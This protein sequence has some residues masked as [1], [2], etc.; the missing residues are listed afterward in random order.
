MD[1]SKFALPP[2][3]ATSESRLRQRLGRTWHAFFARFPHLR[4]IQKAAIEPILR[5]ES[6]I[7][8]APTAAGKTEA[9]L[10]PV[11][12]RYLDNRTACRGEG[13]QVS[14]TS[15]SPVGGAVVQSQAEQPSATWLDAMSR[16]KSARFYSGRT[17]PEITRARRSQSAMGHTDTG[18]GPAILIVAP[19]KALCNDLYR[20]MATPIQNTGLTVALRTGDNPAFNLEQPP[21]VLVTTPESL[22]SLLARR[23]AAFRYIESIIIDEIHLVCASGRGDQLQCL[24]AR[25]RVLCGRDFQICASSATVPELDRIARDFIGPTGRTLS[26]E[27]GAREIHASMHTIR[28]DPQMAIEDTAR[29]LEQLLG[30][31]PQ[32]KILAFCNSRANVEN[33][34]F[35]LRHHASSPTV[36][37]RVFAHHGSLSKEERLRTE[38]Q[39]LRARNAVCVATSTLE[40]GIDIGDVDRIVLLGPPPDVPS[41][42]Q[43]IGRGCRTRESVTA[44]CLA[45][46]PFSANRFYHLVECARHECLFPD[47][48]AIRP[49]TLVQQ[50]LSICLQNPSAWIA[51]QA[52]YERIAPSAQALYSPDDCGRI[53]DAMTQHGLLRKV[54]RGRYVPEAKTQFL[55]D[56]GLM[57][58]M[59]ADRGETDVVDSVTGRTLGSV[60]LK[61]SNKDAVAMGNDVTLTLAGAAH[62]ISCI[63][64]KKIFVKRGDES[65]TMAFMA[66][67]PPRYSLGLARSFARFMHIPDDAL[68]LRA[69]PQMVDSY[70]NFTPQSGDALKLDVPS[71]A[72][73]NADY[74]VNHF[75]GTLGS[76]LLELFF[77][78]KGAPVRKGSRSPFFMRLTVRPSF[79]SF[80]DE[81][82]LTTAFELYIRGNPARFARLLQPGP[83]L[84]TIPEDITLKWLLNSIDVRAYARVLADKPLVIL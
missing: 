65:E 82:R 66:L 69:V 42:I 80:P 50:A 22:D 56:R 49:T 52:L 59:I 12:E 7:V 3:A 78:G 18:K 55:F 15:A 48:V 61:K 26:S 57:H 11:I 84:A 10:A 71:T 68:Y 43:R 54:E 74:H 72:V 41:L 51:K 60:C 58:S 8:N 27:A 34:V 77:D 53:L 83:W 6:L 23:P 16:T 1:G 76:S 24:I 45:D 37:A 33:I 31:S 4:D 17:A 20:R 67:E 19:T 21:Q 14:G 40:L 63:R 62:T 9:L 79:A 81:A 5:G 35:A 29:Y 38:Q 28:T 70:Q 44:C 39:F 36:S 25:L 47:P 75:M 2:K 64:D 32:R 13:M 30:E 73:F 46:S